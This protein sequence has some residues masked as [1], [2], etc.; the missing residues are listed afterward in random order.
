MLT[1]AKILL[2]NCG[3][4]LFFETKY[5]GYTQVSSTFEV[6]FNLGGRF[7]P[8]PHESSN[9]DKETPEK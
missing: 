4:S 7:Y 2:K 5:K 6:E 1:S 3:I 8:F 9:V